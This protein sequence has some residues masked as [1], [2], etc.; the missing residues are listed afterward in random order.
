MI[1]KDILTNLCYTELVYERINKKLQTNFSKGEIESRLH[2]IVLK[3]NEKHFKKKGKN[4]YISV[5]EDGI[6]IVI[7]A[8]TSRIITVDKR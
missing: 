6:T 7:N 5:I 4:I 1:K 2:E 8:N 3:T